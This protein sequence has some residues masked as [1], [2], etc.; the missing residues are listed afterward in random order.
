MDQ[1]GR[2]RPRIVDAELMASLAAAGAV[3]IEGPKACGKTATA[4]QIAASEV[5]LDVDP[6]ARAAA[7]VDPSLVLDGQPPCLIDE[8]QFEPAIWN[9]VRRAVDDRGTPGQFILTG[10]AVPAD[11]A[12]RHVGAGRI[13]RLRM[14]PMTLAEVGRASDTV[15]LEA[16]LSGEPIRAGDPGLTIRDLADRIA[17]GGW[18]GH[19]GLG[20]TQA[21]RIL[22]GY[23]EE[24]ARVDLRRVDGVRRDPQVIRRLF[25]SLA[26]NVATPASVRLLLND[27]NGPDGAM[28][29]ETLAAYLDALARLMITED[30]PAWSPSLRSR[31]RLRAAAVRHLVDPSLAVAAARATP[32]RLLGDLN[33]L[34]FLFENLVVRDLRVYAQALDAQVF[35]YRDESGLEADA[36]LELPDGR[37]AAFEVKLGHADIETAAAHLRKLRDRIDPVATGAPAT[38]AVITGTGFSYTREDGV[39]V[40]AAGA[41]A[42]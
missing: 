35:H 18:P 5:R 14:R 12:T 23:L 38:L 6:T 21:Q 39:G 17:V 24:V 22:R 36:I 8:W 16:L 15:S 25:R 40:I 9:H 7:A 31:T 1:P 20:V 32:A 42:A 41:L 10:S 11:D 26:R 29:E 33:W 28:K 34:G 37:W 19:L 4:R 13:V 27:V 3:L 2:Y 30:L